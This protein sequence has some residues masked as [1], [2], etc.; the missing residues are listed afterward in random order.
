MEREN[1]L[2]GM[3]EFLKKEPHIYRRMIEK[4]EKEL[5]NGSSGKESRTV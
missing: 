5:K 4:I 1:Y 3:L 2:K